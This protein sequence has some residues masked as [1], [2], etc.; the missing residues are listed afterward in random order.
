MAI[1]FLS[2]PV[3]IAVFA[4]APV[5][6]QV[7]TRLIPRLGAEKA[8]GLQHSLLRRTLR[9]VVGAELG[10]VS[11][12]C[13]PNCDHPV[14]AACRDGLGLSL[15]PQRGEDLGTRM[16]NAFSALCPSGPVLLV[17]TD[18]PALT[19]SSLILAARALRE[20]K[21]A[22]FLPAEDGGYVLIGLHRAEPLL[23]SDI[24]WGSD[25]VM[26]QTRKRLLQ[27]GWR[28]QEPQI[29][30]DVDRPA[31]LERLLACGLLDEKFE[32]SR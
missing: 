14:F 19:L 17:G 10:P 16:L 9:T 7:K 20:G 4:K 22:V 21:D 8:A 11:L 12:W 31:D 25:R 5:P 30:W 28:W 2:E 29:L 32:D 1:Q 23:F 6:G 26:A 13:A 24:S 27:L 18:C 15:F 3:S